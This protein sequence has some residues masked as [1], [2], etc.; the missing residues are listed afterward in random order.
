[1]AWANF[2]TGQSFYRNEAEDGETVAYYSRSDVP[3][4]SVIVHI[5]VASVLSLSRMADVQLSPYGAPKSQ[6][7]LLVKAVEFG[8]CSNSVAVGIQPRFCDTSTRVRAVTN[9]S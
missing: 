7:W 6:F 5:F 4:F 2:Y 3:T 9:S 1:M 8:R